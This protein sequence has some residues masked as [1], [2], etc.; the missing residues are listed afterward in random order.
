MKERLEAS[1]PL[2]ATSA[3]ERA[4]KA[5]DRTCKINFANLAPIYFSLISA[6]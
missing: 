6:I 3:V 4:G 1:S 5:T 2:A